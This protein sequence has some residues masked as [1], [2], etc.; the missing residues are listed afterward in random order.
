MQQPE[1]KNARVCALA[2]VMCAATLAQK[3]PPEQKVGTL[4]RVQSGEEY[5]GTYAAATA[6]PGTVRA[7]SVPIVR[8]DQVY[9]ISGSGIEYVV[10]E[11]SRP[12]AHVTVNAPITYWL[13]GEK[14]YFVDIEGKTHPAR[15][16]R[17]T[18]VELGAAL[19][20][21]DPRVWK[22][23][24]GGDRF[25]VRRSDQSI[26]AERLRSKGD[27]TVPVT[28]EATSKGDQYVGYMYWAEDKCSV[29]FEMN[30]KATSAD[31]ID[32]WVSRP[33]VGAKLDK[34][35]CRYNRQTIVHFVWVPE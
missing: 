19:E 20:K 1:P 23:V 4:L 8:T 9:V 18:L 31:R 17:Q 16:A 7:L 10:T 6:A 35:V 25:F 28:Y 5:L 29:P 24:P 12:P 34:K 14:F 11:N 30:L 13:V 33:V 3:I 21:P 32:G 2:L 26:Y 22:S 27:K 15:I